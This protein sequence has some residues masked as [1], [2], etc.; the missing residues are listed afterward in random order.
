MPGLPASKNVQLAEEP[1]SLAEPRPMD[2]NKA[3]AYLATTPMWG[4]VEVVAS[5]R[6]VID[7]AWRILAAM[8]RGHEKYLMIAIDKQPDQQ[9]KIGDRLP[10]GAKIEDI[11][12]DEVCVLINGKKRTLPVSPQGRQLL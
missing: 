8:A 2:V 1:W 7:P 12:Q 4:N 9:L 11:R 10:G 5:E 6:E 3:S